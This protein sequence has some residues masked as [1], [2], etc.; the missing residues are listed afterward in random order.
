MVA[1]L[2]TLSAANEETKFSGNVNIRKYNLANRMSVDEVGRMVGIGLISVVSRVIES[3]LD[4]LTR[5]ASVV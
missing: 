2:A 5:T 3:L 4:N 1:T